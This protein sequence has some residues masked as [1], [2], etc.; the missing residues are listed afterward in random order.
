MVGLDHADAVECAEQ[1]RQEIAFRRFTWNDQLL[2][3]LTAFFGV[4][5]RP[6]HGPTMDQLLD[7]ADTALYEAKD[8]GRNRVEAATRSPEVRACRCSGRDGLATFRGMSPCP[9]PE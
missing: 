9:G 4:A 6:G 7:A 5:T 1:V 3:R 2:A 8:R